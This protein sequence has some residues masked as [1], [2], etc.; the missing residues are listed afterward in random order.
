[1]LGEGAPVACHGVSVAAAA[2]VEGLGVLVAG[3]VALAVVRGRGVLLHEQPPW[4]GVQGAWTWREGAGGPRVGGER[5]EGVF[6][7][8]A[9][10]L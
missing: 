3:L 6:V 2:G 5:A 8:L 10:G 4:V 9:S 7:G 1:M